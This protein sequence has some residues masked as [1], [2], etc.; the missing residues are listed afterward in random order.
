MAEVLKFFADYVLLIYL[1]LLFAALFVIRQVARARKEQRAAVYGLE[2]E[3]A[4]NRLNRAVSGLVAIG[5]L[6]LGE[7][8]LVAFLVPMLPGML[9]LPTSTGNPGAL[10][11]NTIPPGILETIQAATP[12]ATETLAAS[13]CIPGQIT[14]TSPKAGEQIKGTITLKGTA[15]IPNFGF[16]KYEFSPTGV[17]N[18]QTIQAGRDVVQ[19]GDLGDWNTSLLVPGDYNLR[20]VVVDNQGQSLPACVVPVRILSP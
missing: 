15:D 19:E 18:W 9:M 7:L 11:T 20:L 4:R 10:P 16:Y 12:G 2:I 14:L 1:V 3:I 8:V 6:A 17:E 5:L 13:G